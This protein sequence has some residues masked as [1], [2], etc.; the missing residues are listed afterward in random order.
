MKKFSYVV[1]RLFQNRAGD[2]F[3]FCGLLIISEVYTHC[4]GIIFQETIFL[5]KPP[6]FTYS[7]RVRFLLAHCFKQSFQELML[8]YL[9]S[10]KK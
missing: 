2:F 1:L 9:R 4:T 6:N 8:I 3:K 10:T 7:L 5:Q